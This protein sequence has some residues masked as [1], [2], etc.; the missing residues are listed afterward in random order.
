MFDDPHLNANG[1]LGAVTLPDGRTSKLP[2]LPIE[3]DGRRP[4]QG[5]HLARVGEHTAELLRG[6]GLGERE[7]ADLAASRVIDIDPK[8][9]AK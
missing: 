6:L 2:I 9:P 7:I 5:G 4:T 3:M 8:G 1:S